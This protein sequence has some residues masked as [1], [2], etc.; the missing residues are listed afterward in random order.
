MYENTSEDIIANTSH[1]CA[2]TGRASHSRYAS[3][4]NPL[5]LLF[6]YHASTTVECGESSPPNPSCPTLWS[7]R[8][9][10]GY[11]PPLAVTQRTVSVTEGGTSSCPPLESS[12][13]KNFVTPGGDNSPRSTVQCYTL[14]TPTTKR[15]L[16]Q[17]YSPP[18]APSIQHHT[19]KIISN[20]L[21]PTRTL[22]LY[23]VLM[24][25]RVKEWRQS[26]RECEY[27]NLMQT[28]NRVQ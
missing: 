12:L 3:W 16:P 21:R 26:F 27:A 22:F 8:L 24:F 14:K 10:Q 11:C 13:G 25:V 5:L 20:Q 28:W 17:R 4:T 23:L 7:A 6:Y 15:E 9:G 2:T 19:D 18:F 1:N